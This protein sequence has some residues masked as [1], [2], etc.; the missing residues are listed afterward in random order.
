MAREQYDYD[1]IDAIQGG[2][3]HWWVVRMA[4]EQYDYDQIDA[5]P[6]G[7]NIDQ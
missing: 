4:R 5:I 3:K 6:R 2:G 1:Q 7:G